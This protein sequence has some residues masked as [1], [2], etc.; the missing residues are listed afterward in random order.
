MATGGGMGH[1]HTMSAAKTQQAKCLVTVHFE[2][3]IDLT[4]YYDEPIYVTGFFRIR[5]MSHIPA[6]PPAA[7]DKTVNSMVVSRSIACE[8]PRVIT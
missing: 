3:I 5:S 2:A 6:K 8:V 1:V 4:H 7:V